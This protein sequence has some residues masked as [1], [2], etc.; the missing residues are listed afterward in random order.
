MLCPP[1][2]HFPNSAMRRPIITIVLPALMGLLHGADLRAQDASCEGLPVKSVEVESQRPVFRGILATWRNV[3]RAV[4]L[5]HENT[6]EGLIRRFVTLDPG[7]PCTEFR[8]SETERI[9]RAQ[10]Y[11]SDAVV[12]TRR[13]GDSVE[14][15]VATV[16]E[17]PVVAGM[18]LRGASPQAANFG[19]MNLFGTGL[20]VESRWEHGRVLRT[21]FG[22]KIAHPQLFGRPYEVVLDG[23]R[24]PLG[25]YYSVSV[26]HPFFTD[27]QR[28]AWHTGWGVSKDFAPLRRPDKSLLVQPVDRAMLHVGGVVRFGP[29]RKLGL[30]GAMVLADYVQTRNN[31]G[32]MDSTGRVLPAPDTAGVGSYPAHDETHVAGVVGVRALRF[33][34]VRGLDALEAEQDIATGTQFGAIFGVRPSVTNAFSSAFGAVDLYVGRRSRRNFAGLRVDVQSRM[35]I[36]RSEWE[37][38]VGSGRAAWY[39]QPRA[40]WVSEL[41]VEG[42]GVWRSIL[43]FQIELGDRR[44]GVR[45]YAGAHEAG[46]QRLVARFEQRVDLARYQSTRAAIGGAAFVDMGRVWSGEAPFGVTTPVRGSA[47]LAVLA[48]VPARSR[49]TV[50]MELAL[51]FDRSRGA[52]AEL[53][54]VVRE[55]AAGFWA[56]PPRIRWARLSAV[57]EQIFSW[58]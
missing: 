52:G 8:A 42:A 53:R 32:L 12:T 21:G 43:P 41:S 2:G 15:H 24:R 6:S 56:E 38:L 37:H 22:G 50:R 26:S 54:F 36:D 29:P 44:S 28:F 48:A 14:V 57:P 7:R 4:G 19:T 40:R 3:A 16:D 58:P 25:E 47:G 34:R 33:A 27:L 39:F 17:V 51:P 55:P 35:S 49:R 5:H 1:T 31:I 46:A 18:R 9:L 11:I 30:I 13:V 45:G 23:M 10:P 20:H